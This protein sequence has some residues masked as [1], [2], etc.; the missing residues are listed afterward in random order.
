M[1][2][3]IFHRDFDEVPVLRFVLLQAFVRSRHQ[4]I[5]A[6]QLWFA[7]KDAAVSIHTGAEFQLQNE[8]FWKLLYGIN[9]PGEFVHLRREGDR[10]D[11]LFGRVMRIAGDG[12]AIKLFQDLPSLGFLFLCLRSEAPACEVRAIEETFEPWLRLPLLR[13]DA[14]NEKG[15]DDEDVFHE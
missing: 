5:A 4:V 14:G 6:L 9:L 1:G 8:V 12:F 11:A 10:E 7:D 13:V 2:H 15:G 3:A